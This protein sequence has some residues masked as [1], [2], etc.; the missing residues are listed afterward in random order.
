MG[1]ARILFTS[2]EEIECLKTAA[3]RGPA[4]EIIFSRVFDIIISL[5]CFKDWDICLQQAPPRR[6][7]LNSYW[8]EIING[9]MSSR[10]TTQLYYCWPFF[11][12]PNEMFRVPFDLDIAERKQRELTRKH[13]VYRLLTL[14]MP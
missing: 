10:Y 8:K 9:R 4:K 5:I 2:Y 13:V 1:S 3:V 7:E 12:K 6:R 11:F 14:L